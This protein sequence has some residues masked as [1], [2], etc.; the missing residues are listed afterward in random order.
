MR[1]GVVFVIAAAA[2][3]WATAQQPRPDPR[4]PK[5][6]VPPLEYRSAFES[7]R[8]YSEPEVSGWREV[9]EEVRRIG[10]HVGIVRE[11]GN[12]AKPDAK[13]AR[14]AGHGGHK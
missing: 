13:P 8:R 14:D 3:G 6:K 5:V 11:Q 4:D 9:N 7:Y 1:K 12:S 10:G 2:A